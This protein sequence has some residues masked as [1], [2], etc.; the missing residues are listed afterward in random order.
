MSSP[1]TTYLT[2]RETDEA[3][4][5]VAKLVQ[6]QMFMEVVRMLEDSEK[7]TNVTRQGSSL[8]KSSPSALRKLRPVLIGSVLR[9]GGRLQNSDLPFDERHPIL[10]PRRHHVSMVMKSIITMLRLDTAELSMFWPQRER[11]FG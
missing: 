9:V 8:G 4:L 10:L 7:L 5:A 6:G 11:R 3:L 2:I 1:P